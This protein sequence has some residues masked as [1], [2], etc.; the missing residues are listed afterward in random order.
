MLSRP[1][2]DPRALR[3]PRA[4]RCRPADGRAAA[5]RGPAVAPAA[6]GARAPR[7][8]QADASAVPRRAHARVRVH[9]ARRRRARPRALAV[10]RAVPAPPA[11]AVDHARRDPAR[12]V[13]R[14]RRGRRARLAERLGRLLASTSSV[15]LQFGVLLSRRLGGP[16][17][18]AR[19]QALT[20]ARSTRC[21][22]RRSPSAAPTR[23]R[24]SSR[25]SSRARFEDGESMDDGEIRDQLMTLLLAGHETTATGLAWTFDL[26]LRHPHVLDR[27]VRR[28]RRGR[29][30]LRARGRRGVPAPAAGRPA[31]RPPTER[32]SCA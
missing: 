13:R 9:R 25:C 32:A 15:G 21:S 6:R 31:R 5:D 30:C 12:R 14:H 2:R 24:T 27:L 22:P 17:P 18:L 8:P 26:L 20:A 3:R 7:A 11:H 4:R 28:R 19:L 16:D 10:G 23:A 29:G 1:G